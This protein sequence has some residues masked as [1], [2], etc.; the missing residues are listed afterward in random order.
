MQ[1]ND[2]PVQT[3]TGIAVVMYVAL[4]VLNSARLKNLITLSRRYQSPA[5]C[6]LKEMA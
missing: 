3:E 1:G 2:R 5:A 6:G 4:G